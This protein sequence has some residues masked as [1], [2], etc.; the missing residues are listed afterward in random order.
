MLMGDDEVFMLHPEGPVRPIATRVPWRSAHEPYSTACPHI[1][2][3]PPSTAELQVI[4]KL[5]LPYDRHLH[6]EAINYQKFPTHFFEHWNGF[7][8][9]PPLHGPTPVMLLEGCPCEPR[10]VDDK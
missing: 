3:P 6:S 2:N 10:Y 1:R 4:A 5:S 7:N 9:V 8:V